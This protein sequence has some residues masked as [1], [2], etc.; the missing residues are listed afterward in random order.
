V[1]AE[2]AE[3]HRRRIAGRATSFRIDDELRR[4]VDDWIAQRHTCPNFSE[5]VRYALRE[6]VERSS[7]GDRS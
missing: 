3:Q 1:P 2:T 4:Q 5:A 6:L 7:N